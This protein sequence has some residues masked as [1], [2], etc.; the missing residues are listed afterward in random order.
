MKSQDYTE[1]Q[2]AMLLQYDNC[3]AITLKPSP[4]FWPYAQQLEDDLQTVFPNYCYDWYLVR[5]TGQGGNVHYH[6]LATFRS[7]KKR[8]AFQVYFNR[9]FG[10]Y[11]QSTKGDVIGWVRYFTKNQVPYLFDQKFEP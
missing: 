3:E 5:E 2:C 9:N 8:K 7:D 11:K 1:D 6:G 4:M 10:K